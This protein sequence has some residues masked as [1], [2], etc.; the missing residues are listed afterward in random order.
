[1]HRDRSRY[2]NIILLLLAAGSV[3]V[4]LL[5]IFG[6][7]VGIVMMVLAFL[8]LLAFLILPTFL[9]HNGFVMMRK[10]GKSLANLLSLLLGL[11]L[12]MPI[13]KWNEHFEEK[14]ESTH[15]F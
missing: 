11:V 8:F 14:L 15:L 1:M 9:I 6:Q 4:L 10:E 12:R 13:I 7:A 3:F 2:R 5:S